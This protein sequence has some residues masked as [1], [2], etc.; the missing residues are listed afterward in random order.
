MK[1]CILADEWTTWNADKRTDRLF[2]VC[3]ACGKSGSHITDAPSRV[4]PASAA[5]DGFSRTSASADRKLAFEQG[6]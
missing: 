2:M 6:G 5:A 4:R 3:P 1:R